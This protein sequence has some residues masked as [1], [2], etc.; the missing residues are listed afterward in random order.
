[1]KEIQ[2]IYLKDSRMSSSE[3]NIAVLTSAKWEYDRGKFPS[4][5]LVSKSMSSMKSP[6]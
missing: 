5:Y 4:C 1:M 3:N 2:K 6:K